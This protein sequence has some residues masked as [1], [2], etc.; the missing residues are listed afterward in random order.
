MGKRNVAVSRGASSS[1]PSKK[2]KG[3]GS[4]VGTDRLN[5]DAR[6]I[7]KDGIQ[8]DRAPSSRAACVACEKVIGKDEPR[9]G[10]KYAGNP[11]KEPVIPL[12]G[13]HPMVMWCHAGGCGLSFVRVSP[14]WPEAAR[15]CHLCSTRAHDKGLRL[16][17]GGK[18]KGKKIRHHA[19]H[20]R[21][22]VKA[23]NASSV[24]Q[25]GKDAILVDPT[26]IDRKAFLPGALRWNDLSDAEQELVRREW[27]G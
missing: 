8:A 17:C 5:V 3:G 10:I 15:V 1:V 6:G 13:T 18:D 12:Y 26:K 19:F 11:L 27:N 16:L 4:D 25:E 20:I 24:D 7:H 14:D 21:C 22:F 2:A 23:I 9:W